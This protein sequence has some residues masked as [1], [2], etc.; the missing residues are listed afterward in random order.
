MAVIDSK[1]ANLFYQQKVL[2]FLP[3]FHNDKRSIVR[4]IY[5]IAALEYAALANISRLLAR[6]VKFQIGRL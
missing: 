1:I 3:A 4:A 6:S 5:Q 2:K